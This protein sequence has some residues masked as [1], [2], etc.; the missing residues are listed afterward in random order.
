VEDALAPLGFAR[1][2]TPFVPHLT[3]GRVR[4]AAPD[5]WASV[6]TACGGDS[7]AG[8]AD[9]RGE[10]PAFLADGFGLWR[11]ALGPSGAR[12]TLVRRFGL[13]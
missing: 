8:Q 10:W 6:L 1:S 9:G 3:L 13:G 2:A 7:R 4:R 5:D 12:H 11:S